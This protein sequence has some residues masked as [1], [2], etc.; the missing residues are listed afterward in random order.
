MDDMGRE[1]GTPGGDSE[2]CAAGGG[3]WLSN[4]LNRHQCT[5]IPK[6]VVH[7]INSAAK[8]LSAGFLGA[9]FL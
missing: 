4:H 6:F 2:S 9:P 7:I 5:R 3:A 1:Q 8:L